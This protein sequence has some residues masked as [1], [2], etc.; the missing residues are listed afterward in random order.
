MSLFLIAGSIA[1]TLCSCAATDSS[2]VVGY[3]DE[4][5]ITME[6]FNYFLSQQKSSVCQSYSQLYGITSFDSAFWNNEYGDSTP[7]DSARAS[8]KEA[9]LE[10]Y[11][12]Q[13]LAE[14]TTSAEFLSFSQLKENAE[15]F[16]TARKESTSNGGIVYGPIEYSFDSYYHR[17]LSQLENDIK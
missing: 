13:M 1:S 16:N 14:K 2:A 9:C 17:Y 11:A 5:P 7:L 15:N 4:H 12:T 8:A 6:E 10:A 3:I